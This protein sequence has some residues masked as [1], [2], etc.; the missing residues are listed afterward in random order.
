MGTCNPRLGLPR[1]VLVGAGAL[2]SAVALELARSA[3]KGELL[4]DSVLI[5]DPGVLEQRNVALSEVYQA[6]AAHSGAGAPAENKATL[7]ARALRQEGSA[8]WTA[9][10]VAIADLGWED[11]A[12]C[13]LI[14]SCTDHAL[15]RVETA[16]V[17]RSLHIPMLDGGVLGGDDLHGEGCGRV[18]WFSP[19]DEA[20][21]YL[22]GLAESRRADLLSFASVGSTGCRPAEVISP[23]GPF[24][25]V[26][27]AIR[28][29]A[30]VLA[31]AVQGFAASRG[32]AHTEEN[33]W[34]V[35]SR[36]VNSRT[37]NSWAVNSR[38]VHSWAVRLKA[39]DEAAPE[40]HRLTRSTSCPWHQPPA[41]PLTAFPADVPL[42][43]SLPR[44]DCAPLRQGDPSR[45]D[46]KV[47]LTWPVCLIAHC[48]VCGA[49]Q[50][51]TQRLAALRLG[52]VCAQC[53]SRA[54]LDPVRSV[55]S[56]GPGDP[57]ADWTPRQLGMPERHLYRLRRAFHPL[58]P[59]T[60]ASEAGAASEASA[61]REGYLP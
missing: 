8:R 46:W 47:Q 14:V 2:G 57:E 54:Q 40:R 18:A 29:V 59:I 38:A 27:R 9:A 51:L 13:D 10:P 39:L 42:R 25:E 6:L 49:R 48:R 41:G 15:A 36:T 28:R 53:G 22:C 11:V 4:L 16:F 52:G 3:G 26:P 32:A 43:E 37:V 31:E 34:A 61:A 60:A 56:V 33:S 23:M 58:V 19:Q 24:P 21:C 45:G 5:V 20:A 44:Q 35:N 55:H 50:E 1:L 30:R 7:L 12:A 17:A